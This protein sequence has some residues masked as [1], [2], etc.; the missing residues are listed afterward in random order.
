MLKY[1]SKC[2][3]RLYKIQTRVQQNVYNAY[4]TIY[5]KFNQTFCQ[6]TILCF[7]IKLS[8][9]PFYFESKIKLIKEIM[10]MASCVIN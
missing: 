5:T 10:F 8:D 7:H 3:F 9:E 6:Q 1:L 4:V 2:V